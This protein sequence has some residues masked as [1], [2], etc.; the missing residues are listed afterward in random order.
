MTVVAERWELSLLFLDHTKLVTLWLKSCF[1]EQKCMEQPRVMAALGL[2]FLILWICK[3]TL[4]TSN[5]QPGKGLESAERQAFGACP[6]GIFLTGLRWEDPPWMWTAPFQ[7]LG[8]WLNERDR[9][10]QALACIYP[11]L[12]LL[13]CGCNMLLLPWFLTV[14]VRYLE[15]TV[16]QTNSFSLSCFC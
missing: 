1:Q 9:G 14:V 8:P 12:A 16:S 5:C 3:V 10:S 7:W 6:W 4:V 15:F 11:L 2:P 13:Y